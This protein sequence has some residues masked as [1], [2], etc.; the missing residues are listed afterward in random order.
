METIKIP[1]IGFSIDNLENEKALEIINSALEKGYRHFDTTMLSNNL[2]ILAKSIEES[3][4]TRS[5]IIIT[6]KIPNTIIT[7]EELI[8]NFNIILKMFDTKYIDF[9]LIHW[10]VEKQRNNDLWQQMQIYQNQEQVHA[11]GVANFQI[12]HLDDLLQE[13]TI[14]PM[15]NQIEMHPHLNQMKLKTYLDDMNIAMTGYF[16]KTF[17]NLLTNDIL[18][19]L[20]NKYQKTPTEIILKWAIQ[21]QIFMLV[22]DEQIDDGLN[23]TDFKLVMHEIEQ[24]NTINIAKRYCQDPDN[25]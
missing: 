10:P 13:A 1:A 9:L 22:T 11:I 7:S 4:I 8:K 16:P 5:E 12:H 6:I 15:M 18:L 24:I 3:S 14:V 20:S 25:I 2:E 19:K 17:D 23:I 21:R